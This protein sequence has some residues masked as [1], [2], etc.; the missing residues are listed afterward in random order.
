M[1]ILDLADE[2]LRIIFEHVASEPEK[3]IS[4]ERRAYL[5]QESFKPP[6]PIEPDQAETIANVRLTC[7][8]FADLGAIHQFSRVTTRFSRRGLKRLENIASQRHLAERV[9]KF[10]Y[11]VPFFYVEGRER[12]QDLLRTLP[13]DLG[14][15]DASHFVQKIKE[16]KDIVRTQEDARVLTLAISAFTSLQHVQ[17]LRLQDQEDGM[18]MQYIRTHHEV[19]QMVELKWPP[20]CLHSTKTIGEALIASKSQCSRFSSPML[21]PVSVLGAANN[22]PSAMALLAERL[23]CLEL[24]FD[25]GID[26][27]QRMRDL[28]SLSKA[29]FTAAKN[30]E[31]VHI[32]FPSHRPLTLKLEEI[33]HNVKWDKLQAFGIQA[34]RLDAEEIIAL[35]NRHK[36]TL[37]GLRLRDVLLKEG[38]RWRDV[39]SFLRENMS[40]LDWVSLRRI[41]YEKHFD[42][43]WIMGAEVP[44]DPLG[45]DSSDESDDWDPHD[46]DYDHAVDQ[47]E[48]YVSDDG[49]VGDSDSDAGTDEPEEGGNLHFPPLSPDTP[50]SVPWCT[51]NGHMDSADFL[52]DDGQLVSYQQRKFW[53]KWVVRKA[54]TEQHGHK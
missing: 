48:A 36:E 22:P 28:S 54:C 18:L 8:K 51:C 53:E 16:Q 15:L 27:D 4:L 39:L 38:S 47:D 45:S 1:G 37:R 52:N 44:D 24:H 32:G 9:K 5:S 7:R 49:S 23:T 50:A 10:S 25:D 17:I 31:A 33:F 19:S 6:P 2:L 20:A 40:R 11:M 21:S 35:A 42:D 14:L 34:W 13:G 12:V 3:L 43:A 29:V 46:D 26:L 30:I 41:D